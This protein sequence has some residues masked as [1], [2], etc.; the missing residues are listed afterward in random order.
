MTNTRSKNSIIALATL[1]VYIGLLMAGGTP[2]LGHQAAMTRNFDVKDELELKE[3]LDKKPDDE[4]SPVTAS[5]QIFLEDIEYFLASLER[6]RSKGRFD[7]NHDKFYVAQNTLL[8]CIDSNLAGRYTPVRFETTSADSRRA[9]EY[10]S[11]GMQYGYLLGDCV[12]NAEFNGVNAAES[13]FSFGLDDREFQVNVSV[14]KD[15][16]QRAAALAREVE[17]SMRLYSGDGSPAI[18]RRLIETTAVRSAND[19]VS[20]V[21]RL[22]RAGLVSLLSTNAQ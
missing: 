16:P 2:V 22:P 21:T 1:G 8:P 7:P 3:K 9:L 5:V 19:Q 11:R 12:V 15:S 10:F 17:A 13:R 14:R 20:V 18:R 4:R 6:L